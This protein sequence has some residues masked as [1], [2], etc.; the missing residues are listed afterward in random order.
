MEII[1]EKAIGR[2]PKLVA[3]SFQL[4]VK[5]ANVLKMLAKKH[6]LKQWKI[7]E[8]GIILAAEQLATTGAL[9]SESE[10]EILNHV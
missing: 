4:H 7:I 9:E 10:E 6:G 1:V 2:P 5:Y 3:R 8:I